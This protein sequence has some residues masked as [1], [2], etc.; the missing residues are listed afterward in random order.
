MNVK[1]LLF[2]LSLV[3]AIAVGV[4]W[5]QPA[6]TEVLDKRATVDVA[7][8]NL[9]QVQTIAANVAVLSRN[10]DDNTDREQLI[11][12]Y[13]PKA[14]D[15]ERMIDVSNFLASESGI[16]LSSVKMELMK[17]ELVQSAAAR[18]SAQSEI[19]EVGEVSPTSAA[20][21][22]VALAPALTLV[23]S[24]PETRMRAEDVTLSVLGR[25]EQIKMFL[26]KLYRSNR[27][28]Q[29][30]AI[31]IQTPSQSS[32]NQSEGATAIS[33]DILQ[34]TFTVRFSFLPVA[35][36][37]EGTYVPIFEKTAF[38]FKVADDLQGMIT[39]VVAPLDVTPSPR[40]N[41]FVQ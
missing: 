8:Q 30:R 17:S 27:L 31:S 18:Q 29:F 7:N 19:K 10:L 40:S 15:D 37:D 38:D 39:S 34:G 14:Q 33:S 16:L 23:Q 5:I 35:S 6:L 25:Y 9:Q 41:P 4:F 24:S 26:E 36:L 1:M 28:N 20:A 12:T 22:A 13:F 2:P 32:G 21:T 11:V 3:I